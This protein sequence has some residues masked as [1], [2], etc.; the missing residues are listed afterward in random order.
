QAMGKEIKLRK[1]RTRSIRPS[2][3]LNRLA[4]ALSVAIIL[5]LLSLLIPFYAPT[6]ILWKLRIG[7]TEF[8]HYL[9]VISALL[10]LFVALCRSWSPWRWI[11]VLL[12]AG[13]FSQFIRPYWGARKI[14]KTLPALLEQS[15][16]K[17]PNFERKP[18]SK[19]RLFW[20]HWV[21]TP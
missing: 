3:H 14:A 18:M 19:K 4:L 6:D 7:V 11:L 10:G 8:G 2:Y 17:L 16:G 21:S 15:F 1:I 12:L 13:S 5:A 20:H 9:A